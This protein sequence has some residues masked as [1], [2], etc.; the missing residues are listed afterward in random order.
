M[1]ILHILNIWAPMITKEQLKKILTPDGTTFAIINAIGL[2]PFP[3]HTCICIIVES[4]ACTPLT[5][6]I[7]ELYI[8]I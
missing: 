8:I 5:F 2:G 3:L 7:L 6:E 1:S 4:T